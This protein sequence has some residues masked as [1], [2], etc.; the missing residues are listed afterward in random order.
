MK[1][2]LPI[3]LLAAVLSGCDSIETDFID[4]SVTGRVADAST[5]E[6]LPDAAVRFAW[7][8]PPETGQVLAIT[9]ADDDGVY[10]QIFR[11]VGSCATRGALVLRAEAPGY[12]PSG[13]VT[14]PCLDGDVVAEVDFALVAAD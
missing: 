9:S 13:V 12:D 8:E 7:E 1:A 11:A 10:L 6:P 2:L 5:G 4:G 14:V 3:V